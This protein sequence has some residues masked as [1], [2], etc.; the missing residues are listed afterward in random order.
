MSTRIFQQQ[1]VSYRHIHDTINML[2]AAAREADPDAQPDAVKAVQA[3]TAAVTGARKDIYFA[4]VEVNGITAGFIGGVL[5]P[6]VFEERTF[7]QDILAYVKP[8]HRDTHAVRDLGK[9]F[10]NWCF[11]MGAYEVRGYLTNGENAER[12]A[13]AAVRDGWKTTGKI[14]TLKRS[15]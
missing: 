3:I 4:V 13:G 1:D 15:E 12:L 5:S 2:S 7:V 9:A 8:E 10:A 6:F 14:I 11:D